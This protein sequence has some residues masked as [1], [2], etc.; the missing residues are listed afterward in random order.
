MEEDKQEQEIKEETKQTSEAEN[1]N[2]KADEIIK[3]KQELEE[4]DDRLKRLMAE[5]D[6]FKKRSGKERE[7]LYGS[8]LSDI[9]SS[10]LPVL[11]NLENAANAET[12]DENY[13]QGIEL[14]L[15]Q[16]KDVLSANNVKEIE[17]VG[18]TF[19]PELHEAVSSVV[20]ETLGEKVV[21]EVYRKGYK[22]GNKVIRHSMVVV[23]N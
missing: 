4:K 21:K 9:I 2:N 13:K 6:N 20:D 23:A 16:F 18:Q 1:I 12:A 8:I 3:L 19:D 17:A 11:D 15:K 5:F 14:V 22:I 7:F 10:L